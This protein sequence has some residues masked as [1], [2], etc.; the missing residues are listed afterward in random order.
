MT[1]S[2]KITRRTFLKG[3]A[4][5]VTVPLL[6]VGVLKGSSQIVS[7]ARAPD[8]IQKHSYIPNKVN[9]KGRYYRPTDLFH[10]E[11]SWPEIEMGEHGPYEILART[12]G[13]SFNSEGRDAFQLCETITDK[14]N[15]LFK[16]N[17]FGH[18]QLNLPQVT[19]A[20]IDAAGFKL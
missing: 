1:D 8:V 14:V 5:G 9:V 13:L 12:S 7:E 16:Q 4:V 19:Q 6:P 10:L 17:G 15:L 2:L 18:V 3:L 11:V 20:F